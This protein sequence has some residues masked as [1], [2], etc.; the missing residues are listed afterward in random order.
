MQGRQMIYFTLHE[1]ILIF[2][3]SLWVT[4]VKWFAGPFYVLDD[5]YSMLV[6]YFHL[7][8]Q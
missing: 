6:V 5:F 2:E 8:I 3:S 4:R 7:S 1:N